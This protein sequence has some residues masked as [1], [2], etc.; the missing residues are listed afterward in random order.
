MTIVGWQTP[1]VVV[2]GGCSR[3]R[4]VIQW[5]HFKRTLLQLF[6]IV[7][8]NTKDPLEAHACILTGCNQSRCDDDDVWGWFFWVFFITADKW[9]VRAAFYM[10]P[11]AESHKRAIQDLKYKQK[12]IMSHS[13]AVLMKACTR[14]V[15]QTSRKKSL[16]VSLAVFQ[17]PESQ[18]FFVGTLLK[19]WPQ[20]TEKWLY[21]TKD[22]SWCNASQVF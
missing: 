11:R 17:E 14:I 22:L 4:C 21:A 9:I 5:V 16:K 19:R 15:S 18:T 20:F 8:A 3:K 2:S 12:I 1:I 13:T 7:N 10:Q 6:C